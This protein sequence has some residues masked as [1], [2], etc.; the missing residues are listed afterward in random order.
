MED[1]ITDTLQRQGDWS[2]ETGRTSSQH[3]ITAEQYLSD[4]LQKHITADPLEY[5][6]KQFKIQLSQT[7]YTP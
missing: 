3:T 2:Q 4:Q 1:P 7:N 6:L 5:I